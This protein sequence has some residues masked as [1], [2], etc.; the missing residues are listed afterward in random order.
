MLL[1]GSG[2]FFVF[3][4]SLLM[5]SM[6]HRGVSLP[7]HQLVDACVPRFWWLYFY[8][9]FFRHEF[10]LLL[11]LYSKDVKSFFLFLKS[12]EKAKAAYVLRNCQGFRETTILYSAWHEFS[13]FT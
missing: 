3:S 2:L 12:I 7:L 13:I 8:N 5:G 1:Y 6:P 9:E 10:L 11:E 4:P